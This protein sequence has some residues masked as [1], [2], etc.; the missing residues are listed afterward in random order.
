VI[1]L[2]ATGACASDINLGATAR[3]TAMGG[4]GIALADDSGTTTML[5]PAAPACAGARFRFIFPGLD[6]HTTGASFG[7]LTDSLSKI[8]GG[9]DDALSLINDFAKQRTSLSLNTI[10]GF[11][12]PF[13]VTVEAQTNGIITPSAEA[14]KWAT[15][16]QLFAN[17]SNLDL[18]ALQATLNNANFNAAVTN[19]L[20]DNMPAANTAFDAYLN[21]LNQSFVDANVVYGPGFLL[22]KGLNTAN[23]RLWLGTNV[24]IL[25][26]QG[27]TWQIAAARSSSLRVTGGNVLT[28]LAFDA[29]ELAG[30]GKT[31]TMKADV[32]M[33]YKPNDSIFQYGVVVNNFIKP[34]IRGLTD[35]QEEMMLSGG[36]AAVVGRNLTVAADLVNIAGANGEKA[37]LRMG[38]EFRLGRMFAARA[39]YSGSQWTTGFELLGLN[40]SWAGRSAQLLSNVLKF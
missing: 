3:S 19:A 18:S 25:A 30:S 31:T 37:S 10:T 16:A 9:T 28:D 22:G 1:A 34:K 15:A 5:N 8:G 38:G 7:D 24:K 20:A 2:A 26:T 14:Q 4:A 29:T 21:E 12:G 39:G 6:F 23:G 40:I 11:S 35:T 36:V 17:T 13:G 27:K 33:I 32:G